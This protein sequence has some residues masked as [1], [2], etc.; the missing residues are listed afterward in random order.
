MAST[1]KVP[2]PWSGTQTCVPSPPASSTSRSR[3]RALSLMNS[4]SRDPQSRSIAS[5]TVRDVVRGPGVSSQGL[6]LD[7]V[8]A[9]SLSALDLDPI[10]IVRRPQA[11]PR[12]GAGAA[13]FDLEG[14]VAKSALV[15][16]LG[17][18]HVAHGHGPA[19]A[20][21][22]RRGGGGAHDASTAP[23]RLVA[24][25]IGP[26]VVE[27]KIHEPPR[28]GL[29]AQGDERVASDEAARLVEAHGEAEPGLQWRVLGGQLAPPRAIGLLHA[30]GL[31][32]VV[33]RVPQ[34][35]VPAGALEGVVDV[36]G[37]FHRHVELPAELA[38]VRDAG[39]AHP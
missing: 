33:A 16:T 37:E 26:G 23:D 31:D 1:M 18:L 28:H 29:S 32:G 39:G 17:L 5:L 2:L 14:S 27:D 22:I 10:G 36:G 4:V 20:M 24:Q 34:P 38:H 13:D 21:A 19:Q 8:M 9:C 12:R 30:Q 3:T 11:R 6:R 15:D 7:S 25:R 35:E